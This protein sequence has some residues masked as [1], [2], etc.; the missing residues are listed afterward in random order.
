MFRCNYTI[1]RSQDW[2]TRKAAFSALRFKTLLLSISGLTGWRTFH[3]VTESSQAS[4]FVVSQWFKKFKI[5]QW[6]WKYLP[7]GTL[8]SCAR[9]KSLPPVCGSQRPSATRENVKLNLTYLE[10]LLCN[11][12]CL[13]KT[14]ANRE[15]YKYQYVSVYIQYEY[16]QR[17]SVCDQQCVRAG[18]SDTPSLRDALV[19]YHFHD[20]RISMV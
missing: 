14:P 11:G 17:C 15:I 18:A 20:R 5:N 4:Q 12:A 10:H 13:D 19:Q 2:R 8:W 16:I 3:T 9:F 7:I 1:P 6:T